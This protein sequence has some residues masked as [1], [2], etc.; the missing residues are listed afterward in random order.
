MFMIFAEFLIIV[1]AFRLYYSS[2]PFCV[3]AG[4]S[5]LSA[6]VASRLDALANV[7]GFS[8]VLPMDGFHYSRQQL[9]DMSRNVT[10]DPAAPS[11]EELL[12]RRGSPWTFDA[13]SIVKELTKAKLEGK[14]SLPTYSRQLSDPGKTHRTTSLDFNM[15]DLPSISTLNTTTSK[16]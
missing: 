4:K 2:L 13:A 5:T 10:Q 14:A 3:G 8:V 15:H 16:Y 7:P 6:S 11:Y 1:Y 9:M 12:A